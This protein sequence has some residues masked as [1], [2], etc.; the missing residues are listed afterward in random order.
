MLGPRPS[1]CD[2]VSTINRYRILKK[3][4][5]RAYYSSCR[6]SL[7]FVKSSLEIILSNARK[8]TYTVSVKLNQSRYRPGV[9]QRVPG[10]QG[11]PIT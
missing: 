10:S 5:M 6:V 2:S 8:G 1:S 9:A 4:G 11:S 3:F 7:R